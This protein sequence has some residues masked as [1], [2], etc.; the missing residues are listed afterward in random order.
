MTY[1][2]NIDQHLVWKGLFWN[3]DYTGLLL[4]T[5]TRWYDPEGGRFV[6]E[7]PAGFT[8]GLNLYAYAGNDPVN[9]RDPSGLDASITCEWIDGQIDASHDGIVVVVSTGF[10]SCVSSGGGGGA[11]SGGAL[12][13]GGGGGGGVGGGTVKPSTPISHDPNWKTPGCFVAAGLLAVGGIQDAAYIAGVA[14]AVEAGAPVW[15]ALATV[16]VADAAEVEGWQGIRSST[17]AMAIGLGIQA[18]NFGFGII[19][20]GFTG[21]KPTFGGFLADMVPGLRTR[22]AYRTA[23]ATCSGRS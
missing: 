23:R 9:G 3:S 18:R 13:P 17:R 8:G 22:N 15:A 1:G 21:G 11:T 20:A 10:Y 5:G 14:L 16:A 4:C 19:G 2:G 6:N 7:D 12:P